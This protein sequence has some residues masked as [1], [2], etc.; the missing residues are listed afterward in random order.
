[1]ILKLLNEP[2]IGGRETYH[3]VDLLRGIASI[4]ILVVH[5]KH[6]FQGVDPIGSL[7]S[8]KSVSSYP[9]WEPI[10]YW[11]SNAVQLFWVI[12]G[13][14]FLHVY[15]GRHDETW[16][17][18]TTNRFA[19]LYP[20]HFLTLMIILIAQ[21]YSL[22]AFGGYNIYEHNDF[23]HFLLNLFFASEWGLQKG[24]SFNGPI[25]SVSVEIFSYFAFFIVLKYLRL[26]IISIVTMIGLSCLFYILFKGMVILCLIYFWSGCLVY[27]L[28]KLGNAISL[29]FTLSASIVTFICFILLAI[30]VNAIPRLFVYAPIFGSLVCMV[31][32]FENMVGEK[33]LNI[34][35]YQWIGNTSY[36]NYLWHS[37]LQMLFLICVGLGMVDGNIVYSGYF[38]LIYLAV[39]VGIS[40]LSFRFYEKPLQRYFRRFAAK[41]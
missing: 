1:M 11:G 7:E 33:N 20:L 29:K 3:L 37:P 39:V 27:A 31:A 30:T 38:I 12:S 34:Q 15:G 26:N 2:V 16:T 17:R 5:Y 35:Y 19:R 13:F 25:W 32:V 24:S 18:Y 8:M 10:Y 41:T 36:G 23:Y 40:M 28:M 21:T 6:F 9:F 4:L 14:V 22:H